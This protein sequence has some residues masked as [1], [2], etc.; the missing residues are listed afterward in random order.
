MLITDSAIT[1]K[2]VMAYEVPLSSFFRGT[3]PCS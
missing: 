1:E 2:S 3:R